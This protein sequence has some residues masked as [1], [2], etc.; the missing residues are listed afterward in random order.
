[1]VRRALESDL[2]KKKKAEDADVDP[3]SAEDEYLMSRLTG[4]QRGEF[5]GK[6][7]AL[8]KAIQKK[9]I[10]PDHVTSFDSLVKD[11]PDFA[12]ARYWRAIACL[13]G[14]KPE[15]AK[16]ELQ[17]AIRLLPDF[18]EAQLTMAHLDLEERDLSGAAA[19]IEKSLSLSPGFGDALAMGAYLKFLT[20]V[21]S[22]GHVKSLAND[23]KEAA[24][25]LELARKIG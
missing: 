24:A 1:L 17:E 8:V 3:L 25:Q 16:A 6:R 18:Y 20:T 21:S 19:R 23:V 4:A 5:N 12:A 15:E 14:R 10:R 13:H 2:G 9:Q 7:A 22:K 11:A